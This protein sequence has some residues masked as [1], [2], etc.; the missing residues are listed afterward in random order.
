MSSSTKREKVYDTN[1]EWIDTKPVEIS[2]IKE[3]YIML[4]AL[5]HQF[6]V[7]NKETASKDANG[8]QNGSNE[9]QNTDTEIGKTTQ[10]NKQDQKVYNQK[11]KVS[12]RLRRRRRTKPPN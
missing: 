9:K 10:K 5:L 2:T 8:K 7:Q 12:K 3:Y 1:G 4:D 11:N 6:P